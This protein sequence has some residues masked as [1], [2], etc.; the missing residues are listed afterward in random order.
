M[1]AVETVPPQSI[2]Q[3]DSVSDDKGD[4]DVLQKIIVRIKYINNNFSL[5]HLTDCDW[6]VH[7][8]FVLV[9]EDI[10]PHS[11]IQMESVTHDTGD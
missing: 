4:Y 10:S 9:S 3:K 5:H 7:Q 8:I 6:I 2:I 1:I 11:T